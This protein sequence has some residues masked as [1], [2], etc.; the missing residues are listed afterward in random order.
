MADLFTRTA[1]PE[2]VS[3][4]PDS[5]KFLTAARASVGW[6]KLPQQTFRAH[7]TTAVAV[8]LVL[9]SSDFSAAAVHQ[10]VCS[11]TCS[12]RSAR[13]KTRTSV[14]L[15]T[16]RPTVISNSTIRRVRVSTVHRANSLNYQPSDDGTWATVGLIP[17][18]AG[19][20]S[21][22]RLHAQPNPKDCSAVIG[23]LLEMAFTVASSSRRPFRHVPK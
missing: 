22:R 13:S 11:C 23:L 14:D 8:S 6:R 20:P 9:D 15:S 7:A 18:A 4:Q 12:D 2:A 16:A 10:S 1:A 17:A 19:W 3:P 5:Q 21:P